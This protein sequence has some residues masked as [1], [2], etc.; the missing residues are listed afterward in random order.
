MEHLYVIRD[1]QSS[2]YKYRE[3]KMIVITTIYL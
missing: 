1:R 2:K 3:K